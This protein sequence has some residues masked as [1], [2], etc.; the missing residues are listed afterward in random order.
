MERSKIIKWGIVFTVLTLLAILYKLYNPLNSNLFPKCPFRSITGY[1]C[2]GCGSQTSIHYLLNFD[3]KN[4]VR[5]NLLLILSI[6]YVLAGFVFDLIK[7]PGEKVLKWRKILFG[8]KAIYV[9]LTVIIGFWILRNTGCCR[10][11]L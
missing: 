3:V 1:R 2:P 11:W 9:V 5:A 7:S 6:P 4:A 10:L 8:T